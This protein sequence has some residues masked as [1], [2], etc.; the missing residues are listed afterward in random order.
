MEKFTYKIETDVGTVLFTADITLFV[1]ED[2]AGNKYPEVEYTNQKVTLEYD[3]EQ[4]WHDFII[5]NT[6]LEDAALK[7]LT[8]E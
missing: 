2:Y 3:V 4:L 7:Q 6:E 8:G 1:D 5:G